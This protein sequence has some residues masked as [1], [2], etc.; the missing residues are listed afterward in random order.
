MILLGRH[1]IHLR[2]TMTKKQYFDCCKNFDWYFDF[3]DDYFG[4]AL[5]GKQQQQQRLEQCYID[6]PEWRCIYVAW[7]DY[8]YSG[9]NWGKEQAP[10]PTYEMFGIKGDKE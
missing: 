7:H 2:Y 1:Q 6:H 8:H 9:D 4:V 10:K 3:S 5:P